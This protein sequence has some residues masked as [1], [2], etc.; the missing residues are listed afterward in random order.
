M[1]V[2]NKGLAFIAGVEGIVP[3]PYLDSV[4]VWTFGIGHT[5]HAGA[6]KPKYMTKGKNY[7]VE[8]CMELFKKDMGIYEARVN[9]AVKVPVTQS[10]FD[11]LVSFDFNTGGIF[12]AK[13][14]RLLNSHAPRSEV[15]NAFM[16]WT[17]P[18]EI[19]GRRR[20][21][22]ALFIS[23][24]YAGKGM[25]PVHK[26]NHKGRVSYKGSKLM[27]V[28]EIL[29]NEEPKKKEPVVEQPTYQCPKAKP[30]LLSKI[31]DYF[32]K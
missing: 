24:T 27:N 32:K 30:G 14:T 25:A 16:G 22:K 7:G 28:L 15:A 9:R 17:K 26:A 5:H 18:V 2:S 19:T 11:A 31:F 4:G 8:L 29:D 21:E 20:K 13:L 3:Y 1:K 12:R 10:E 23:G 6:P